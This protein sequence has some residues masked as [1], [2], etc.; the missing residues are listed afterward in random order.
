MEHHNKG[1]RESEV[2]DHV[3]ETA[4][5]ML[6]EDSDNEVNMGLANLNMD[7]SEKGKSRLPSR[8]LDNIEERGEDVPTF[9]SYSQNIARVF[10]EGKGLSRRSPAKRS[11]RIMKR[12]AHLEWSGESPNCKKTGVSVMRNLNHILGG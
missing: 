6:P 11:K 10:R 12:R 5:L 1:I 4:H 8:G 2:M 7:D 9:G 3:A